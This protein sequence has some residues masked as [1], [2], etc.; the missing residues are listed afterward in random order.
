MEESKRRYKSGGGKKGKSGGKVHF[1]DRAIAAAV[2]KKLAAK[3]KAEEEDKKKKDEVEGYTMSCIHC[4]VG[5]GGNLRPTPAAANT[6][7]TTTSVQ[8]LKSIIER[9]KNNKH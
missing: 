5:M 3:D 1:T 9:A 7:S 8:A 2:E 4:L 6:S